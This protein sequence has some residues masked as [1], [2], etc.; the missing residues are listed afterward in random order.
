MHYTSREVYEF[1]S[2][3]TNDP[4]VERKTCTISGQ[5]F[6]IF[7]SDLDFYEKISP[8][9]NGQKF[10][11]PTPTLCPEERQRR[12]LSFRNE[13]KL[14]RRQCDASKKSIISIY[15]PDKLYK[16]Y[17][18]KIRRSDSRD[19][20]DYGM[21]FDFNKTFTENFRELMVQV[22]RSSVHTNNNHNSEY[23]NHTG[24]MKDSYLSFACR[25][26]DN[27]SFS[28]W[29]HNCNF[30]Y[31]WYE[32]LD[33]QNCY[34]CIWCKRWFNLEYC[35][36]C[37]DCSYCIGCDWLTNKQYCIFNKQYTKEEYIHHNNTLQKHYYK[38]LIQVWSDISNCEQCFW[39]ILDNWSNLHFCY[40]INSAKDCKYAI[41]GSLWVIDTYDWYGV[42]Y[43][44][45][46]WYEIVD[47]GLQSN[48]TLFTLVCHW[49]SRNYYVQL[50]YNCS[51]LFWCIWL[52]NKSYCIFNQ[53]YTKEDYEIQVA[54][55]IAHMQTTGEWWEF[56]HPSLSPFG[57]NETVAQEYYYTSSPS[58]L[59][60]EKGDHKNE[61]PSL[62]GEGFGVRFEDLKIFWYKR[63]TYN[64]DPS[65]PEWVQT[66]SRN[67]YSDEQWNDLLSQDNLETQ[68]FLCSVSGRPYRLQKAEIEFYR[69]HHLPIPD[70][71]PDIRHEERMKLRPGRTLFLRSCDCCH[72]E[73]LS[74]YA[75][76]EVPLGDDENHEWKV[77][78][79]QCYQQEMYS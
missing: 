38:K 78:C 28:R 9:F 47:T 48:N 77:Y 1:I 37:Q 67:N 52:R 15:S 14:Y 34:E 46:L 20:M 29:A 42:W 72:K 13:R 21:D 54:K 32:L 41:N 69:K 33:C 56:F 63:S 35:T 76:K 43:T 74:V 45:E 10:Q 62:S 26:S 24:D 61:S 59:L 4:I 64:S 23:T 36:N 22:P 31:E 6:A 2:K 66:I 8:T 49:W 39:D 58:L 65:L 5:P 18:Q 16:V 27:T 73:M 17:D 70:K 53:Q 25:N 12:R 19:P 79:E 3:Q 40:N 44:W 50:C 51:D 55:L 71:H 57:Y 75:P 68:V 11:I 30:C 60:S 7:Q